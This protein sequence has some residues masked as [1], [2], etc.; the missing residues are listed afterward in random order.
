MRAVLPACIL[1]LLP[2]F[3]PAVEPVDYTRQVKPIFARHCISCHGPQTQRNSLRLDSASGILDG[4][5]HGPAVAPGKSAE[6]LLVKAVTGAKGVVA[7]PY[8]KPRLS[9][10]EIAVLRAWIDAGATAPK[11]ETIAQSN[12]RS[13]HWAFQPIK[14]LPPPTVKNVGWVR[15]DID[16]F[17]LAR[18]EKEGVAPSPEADRVTLI[19]RVSLDLL[20]LPPTPQEVDDFVNDARPEAYQHLVD[21][22]LSSPH[23]GERWGRHWLDNARYADSNGYSI[24]APRAIWPYRD[25]VINAVNRDMPFDQFTIEQLAGDMLTNATLQ[26]RVATGFHRNTQINQEGGIDVEQFRVEAVVDRVNTTGSVWLGL[27]VGCCQCHDHKFDPISQREYYQLFAFF[28]TVDEPNLE[29]PTPEALKQRQVVQDQITVLEKRMKALEDVTPAKLEKWEISLTAEHKAKFPKRVRDILTLPPNGRNAKQ[30][31]ELLT[32]Y[33]NVDAVQHIVGGLGLGQ[34]YLLAAHVQTQLTRTTLEKQIIDLKAKIPAIPTT[35]VVQERKPARVTNVMLGGDF[36]RKGATVQPNVPTVLPPLPSAEKATRLDFARWLV[37]PKNP[38]TA[39]VAMNRFWQVYFGAGIVETDNDFGTQGTAPSHPELLDYLAAEF[40]ARKWS[41]K[42]MHRLIVTSATYR[43]SSRSR[44]E[45]AT[46]DQRNRLLA[47]QNRLRLEAEVV[48]DVSLSASGLL[49][50]VVGGP[51]VF[52]PQPPGVYVL[53]QVPREWKTSV[54]PERFRRG[55][56][57]WFQ[58]SAPHPGLIVFDAPD[59]GTTCTRRNRSNTPLQ[60]LTLLNDAASLEFAQGL[61]ARILTEAP[62]GDET[63]LRYVFRLCLSRESSVRERQTLTRLLARQ[64]ATLALAPQD[65]KALAPAELPKGA[66]PTEAAAWTMVA[67]V[68][69]NLDEF[70]T[71]E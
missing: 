36:L 22:L 34:N 56:Y 10:G 50:P 13:T 49:S 17:I 7:M 60:A 32:A 14:R 28:N 33:R 25:W 64:R 35:M 23:Y 69:M 53:T 41:M 68:L 51:S 40:I 18:L 1:V 6:S 11:D 55:M 59:A 5:N 42:A 58:R 26:Q 38:L 48:R 61:A 15:N 19:R 66:D 24:D 65:A 37:D 39:R 21:R 67:R 8:K 70:I 12:T 43:Q 27:T 44:P 3:A 46:M 2:G 62:A 16:N 57:T 31:Q 30:E 63:R 4:G 29:L 71:R 47:R 54:G 52:P 9:A 20:G 45:L